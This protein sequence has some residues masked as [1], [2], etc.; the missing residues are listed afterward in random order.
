MPLHVRESVSLC[1]WF[2]LN[3]FLDSSCLVALAAILYNEDKTLILIMRGGLW[4][5][6]RAFNHA[7]FKEIDFENT[8]QS[9]LNLMSLRVRGKAWQTYVWTRADE[10]SYHH[11]LMAAGFAFLGQTS[12]PNFLSLLASVHPM[13][14]FGG[15]SLAVCILVNWYFLSFLFIMRSFQGKRLFERCIWSSSYLEYFLFGFA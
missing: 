15:G 10:V 8:A 12:C 9:C 1:G 4:S 2:I 6:P 5:H 11:G 3:T 13:V 14:D 7:C